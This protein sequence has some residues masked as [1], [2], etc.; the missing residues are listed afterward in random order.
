MKIIRFLLKAI[1]ALFLVFLITTF[2]WAS[3]VIFYWN[4]GESISTGTVRNGGLKN[5]YK[6]DLYGK[7]F[8]YFSYGS[9]FLLGMGFSNSAVYHSLKDA[10]KLLEETCPEH[11]FYVMELSKKEGGQT[12]LHKTHRNGLSVDLMVPKMKKNGTPTNF[13]DHAGILHYRYEFDKDGYLEFDKSVQIDFDALAE[14][15]FAL[16]KSAKQHGLKVAIVIIR[17]EIKDDLIKTKTGKKIAHLVRSF[18]NHK[19]VNKMHDDHIHVDFAF[20]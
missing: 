17:D 2:I 5:A 14:L 15:I 4:K 20:R 18:P 16:Q 6:F 8:S 7:N 10:M 1:A 3:P 19:F 12:L 9:Y 11:Y 13:Y